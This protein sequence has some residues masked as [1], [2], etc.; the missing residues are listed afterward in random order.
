[1]R[2]IIAIFAIG[3]NAL[4]AH[5]EPAVTIAQLTEQIT[6]TPSLPE[7]YYQR[8]VE[9]LAIEQPAQAKTDFQKAV[10]LRSDYLPAKRYLAQ[11]EFHGGDAA[12][13]LAAIRA[14]IQV[15]PEEHQFLVPGCHQLEGEILLQLKKP[16][17]AL[18]AL[19]AALKAPFPEI[20][21]WRLRAEAQ[22][23]L[24]KV[25]ECISDLHSAWEKTN[26]I[27]LRN[28]WLEAL[29]V[30]PR[31]LEAMPV[32]EKEI[33]SGRFKSSWLIR[34]ARVHL[35]ENRAT[36]AKSDLEAAVAE[37]T[38]RLAVAPPPFLLLCDRGLAYALLGQFEAAAAD[39]AQA[40]SL[41]AQ[42]AHCRQLMALLAAKAPQNH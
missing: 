28:E 42:T 8:G 11:I 2:W 22:R 24:G 14:A 27:I 15:A 30:S 13:A 20:D 1:M 29:I 7:L 35:K 5:H 36:E 16:A 26:A 12:T 21:T 40:K 41:G 10:E 23:Q 38:S 25:D 19:D 33:E 32:I 18:T 31:F 6:R 17:E 4:H 34:R 9:Y 39:L 3:L 37:L